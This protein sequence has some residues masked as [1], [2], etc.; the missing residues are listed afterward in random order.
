MLIGLNSKVTKGKSPLAI[1]SIAAGYRRARRPLPLGRSPNGTKR[2]AVAGKAS[3]TDIVG[4][5]ERWPMYPRGVG[6]PGRYRF[7]TFTEISQDNS[8]PGINPPHDAAG[9]HSTIL[10]RQAW[11]RSMPDGTGPRH[12][13][14]P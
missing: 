9:P 8:H 1:K 4:I 13:P 14:F 12:A 3:H 10:R 11:R 2:L 5:G 6:I 7:G